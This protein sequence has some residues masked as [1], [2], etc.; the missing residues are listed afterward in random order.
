MISGGKKKETAD[1]FNCHCECVCV[2]A[3]C[4]VFHLNCSLNALSPTC[5]PH[6]PPSSRPPPLESLTE[7]V[8][9]L[10]RALSTIC[11]HLSCL[12]PDP[13]ELGW[14]ERGVTCLKLKTNQCV[15]VTHPE[16]PS[17]ARTAAATGRW[18]QSAAR[19]C[20]LTQLCHMS[21]V[22]SEHYKWTDGPRGGF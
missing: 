9:P 10:S 12:H 18:R 20:R 16:R 15:C 13:Q 5:P 7:I 3:L 11:H 17:S 22:S 19:T 4:V 2:H 6:P 14:G 21:R 1:K 8:E